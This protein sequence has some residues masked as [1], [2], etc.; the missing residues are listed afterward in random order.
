MVGD[1][2]NDKIITFGLGGYFDDFRKKVYF[3]SSKRRK[4]TFGVKIFFF[5]I[6]DFSQIKGRRGPKICQ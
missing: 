2:K 4:E 6:C 3:I 5:N 1:P